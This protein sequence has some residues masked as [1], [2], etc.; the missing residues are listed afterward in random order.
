MSS[1]SENSA[2]KTSL[3]DPER[4]HHVAEAYTDAYETRNARKRSGDAKDFHAGKEKYF[5]DQLSL[6]A[7]ILEENVGK[8]AEDVNS[9]LF[10]RWRPWAAKFGGAWIDLKATLWLL[11]HRSFKEAVNFVY[12]RV[13]VP[14]GEG[15]QNLLF[16][17]PY[18][19]RLLRKFSTKAP[20]P[21]YIELEPTTVCNKACVHCEFTYW[22][23]Q[24]QIKRNVTLEEFKYMMDQMPHIRWS[25]ITGEGS[26]FLNK[27]YTGMIKYLYSKF[28]SSNWL[29]DHLTDIDFDTLER[30]VLPYIHG[31]YVSIDAATKETYEKI[32]VGCD[33]D[34]LIINLHKLVEYKRKNKTPFP[35]ITFRYVMMKENA[36]EMP[37]FLRMINSLAEPHEWG[38]MSSR[39]EFTGLLYYP[40]IA[41]HY[42]KDI[43]EEVVEELKRCTDGIYF[44]FAH[45][46]EKSNPPCESCT[47]WLEPYIM[48]PGYVVPCC[49]VMMSNRRPFLRKY[50]F[51]NLLRDDFRKLWASPYYQKFKQ[52]LTD[53]NAPV[54]KICAGC[55]AYRTDHRI[56]K[57]GVWDVYEDPTI[58]NPSQGENPERDV[59]LVTISNAN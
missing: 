29:V 32:K 9:R 7:A 5:E 28:K 3:L 46:E 48:N 57:Y 44:T 22:T 58:P 31:I 50:A 1:Q 15:S 55:R 16:V 18:M 51:G 41:K 10:G 11:R 56:A 6:N 35:H 17:I 19:R 52:L 14:A 34:K 45:G 59:R 21:K 40:E 54:P 8:M 13:V 2:K 36:H 42:L 49:A 26:A 37:K 30:E 47:A 4:G 38:G 24:E 20:F 33:W 27:E 25:N 23:P 39:V 53:P 12:T 43:P